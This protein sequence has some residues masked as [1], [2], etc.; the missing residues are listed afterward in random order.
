MFEALT[1]TA[2]FAGTYILLKAIWKYEEQIENL[3]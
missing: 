2:V 3:K 1:L